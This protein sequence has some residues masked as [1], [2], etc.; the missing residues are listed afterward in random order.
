MAKKKSEATMNYTRIGEQIDVLLTEIYGEYVAQGSPTKLGGLRFLDVP[1]A[2]TF[3]LEKTRPQKKNGNILTISA[4]FV[5][6]K[7]VIESKMKEGP[8]AKEICDFVVRASSDAGKANKFFVEVG[9]KL[10]TDKWLTDSKIAKVSDDEGCNG[11][12]AIKVIL[13]QE[14]LPIAKEVME[15][16]IAVIREF[17]QDSAI[18]V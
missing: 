3:A 10:P 18:I 11:N 12:E 13:R 9:Y 17:S 2:K 16:F 5:G 1:S 15:H 14:V 4:P 6:E 7:D 8:Y